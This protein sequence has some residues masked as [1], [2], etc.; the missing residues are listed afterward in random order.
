MLL[1]DFAFSDQFRGA[2]EHCGPVVSLPSGFP[3]QGPCSDVVTTDA[4]VY[5][6][7][8]VIGVFPPYALKDGVEKPCL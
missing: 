1:T 5:L 4:F 6:P 3:C 8:Y 2:F 7:K